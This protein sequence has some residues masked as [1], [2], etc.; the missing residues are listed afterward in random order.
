MRDPFKIV[1]LLPCWALV[2]RGRGTKSS[3]CAKTL[4]KS[5]DWHRIDRQHARMMDQANR[6][7]G[8]TVVGP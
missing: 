5:G 2:A 3:Y 4:Y 6:E 1:S 8:F 7:N